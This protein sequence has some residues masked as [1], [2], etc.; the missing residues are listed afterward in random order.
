M[1]RVHLIIKPETERY[2]QKINTKYSLLSE[3]AAMHF[4]IKSHKHYMES[5]SKTQELLN[6]IQTSLSCELEG[7]V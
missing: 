7:A 1:K 4:I 2:I 3:T 5:K 6:F